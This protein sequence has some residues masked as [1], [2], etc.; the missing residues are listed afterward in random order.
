MRIEQLIF[1]TNESSRRCSQV[2]NYIQQ[3]EI[4]VTYF[5][6]G[7]KQVANTLKN[8]KH[9]KVSGVPSLVA[10]FEDGNFKVYEGDEC[11]QF[12]QFIVNEVY[13]N[14]NVD[15]SQTEQESM[16]SMSD[17]DELSQELYSED[18]ELIDEY[19]TQQQKDLV[20]DTG[21]VNLQLI[22][23]QAEREREEL[24]KSLGKRRRKMR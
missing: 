22:V 24:E 21:K 17:S 7:S 20:Q 8:G 3:N 9:F 15:E 16:F 4:P 18:A 19:E 12:L 10:I 1:F 14:N 11:N 2:H 6:V 5:R 23:Q 13:S